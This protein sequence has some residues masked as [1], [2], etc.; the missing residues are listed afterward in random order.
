MREPRSKKLSDKPEVIQPVSV[1]ASNEIPMVNFKT[2][3][4]GISVAGGG[5]L[6]HT[7]GVSQ[8]PVTP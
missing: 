2:E 8:L 4:R 6:L 3:T 7:T 5:S 1:R